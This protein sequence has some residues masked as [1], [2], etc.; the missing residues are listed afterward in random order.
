MLKQIRSTRRLD[1]TEEVPITDHLEELRNRVIISLSALAVGFILSFW[2]HN[3]LL[4]ALNRQLPTFVPQPTTLE[5]TEPFFIALKVSFSG[6]VILAIPVLLY[7]LYAFIMPAFDPDHDRR[8]WPFIAAASS[9]FLVGV[10]FGYLLMLPAATNFLLGFDSELYNTEVQAGNFYSF[11]IWIMLGAGFIFELPIGVFLLASV[12]LM[13]AAWMRKNRRYAIF[14]MA[15]VS[16][17]LPGGDPFSMLFALGALL[18]LY[19]VSIYVAQWVEKARNFD[20]EL[21]EADLDAASDA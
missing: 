21:E 12:G 17:A 2:Q 19:E 18:I 20:D 8:T 7:Q 4:E 14:V 11:A 10:A 5:V 16:A 13:K 15:V 9:L 6:A 1:H 3:L